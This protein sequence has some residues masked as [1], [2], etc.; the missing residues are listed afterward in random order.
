MLIKGAS[1]SLRDKLGNRPLD[2]VTDSIPP[3]ARGELVN[4]LGKQPITVPCSQKKTPLKKLSKNFKTF[5]V[6]VLLVSVTYVQLHLFVFPYKPFRDWVLQM[7]IHFV[8]VNVFFLM[9]SFK[10]PGYVESVKGLKFETLVEHVDPLNLC[11]NCEV[12]YTTDSR[13]CYTCNRC[14]HKFD[15][16]CNWIN[17]CVGR[18]NHLVFYFYILSLWLYF[19]ALIIMSFFNFSFHLTKEEFLLVKDYNWLGLEEL[20]FAKVPAFMRGFFD[21]S[22]D[23]EALGSVNAWVLFTLI[24]VFIIAALFMTCLSY[25]LVVQT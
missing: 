20:S 23:N 22:I 16:H 15:H 25:L 6:Y 19:V 11:P 9:A 5:V 1:R 4:I 13:H 12:H 24:E 3:T 21:S 10:N 8:V 18:N 14:V 17:N 7:N 2:L